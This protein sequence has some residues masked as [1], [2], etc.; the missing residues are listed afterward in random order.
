V[1]AEDLNPFTCN[2]S[3]WWLLIRTG[4][5]VPGVFLCPSAD[6]E[7]DIDARAYD[8]RWS[9]TDLRNVS[10]SYQNQLGRGSTDSVDPMLVVA[11]D[12][13][14]YRVDVYNE[15]SSRSEDRR[16][17][18]YQLNSPNH[19]FQG[20][21]CLYADGHVAWTNSPQCGIGGNNIWVRS[22]FT[23]SDLDRPWRDDEEY[24][25]PG[26]RIGGRKDSW[27]VP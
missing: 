5:S 19:D 22:T 9:F 13:N 24:G 25:N 8:R 3:N 23:S 20:Q 1:D 27:L 18:R 7:E 17:D 4:K 14:P 12:V 21:N 16:K 10:Y 26:D 11:A 15:S 6:N 2:L